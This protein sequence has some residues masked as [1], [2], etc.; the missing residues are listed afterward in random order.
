MNLKENV[1]RYALD[2]VQDDMVL[3]LGSGSTIQ[4]FIRLLGESW[5]REEIRGIQLVPTSTTSAELA[6]SYGLPLCS[7][8]DVDAV[9]LA[10]DGADEVDPHLNLIKGLGLALLREKIIEIHA[11]KFLVIVDESKLVSRLGRGALPVEIVPF[12][13]EAHLRWLNT[14]DCRAELWCDE[15]GKPLV[16]DNGNYVCRCWFDDGIINLARMDW[17]LNMR[18]GIVEH[19]LFINMA[20]EV[21]V[22]GKRNV[23]C[24][25]KDPLHG[26]VKEKVLVEME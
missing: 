1:A 19:G 23:K 3:G 20:D 10:I 9:D 17:L 2:Y 12:E 16:T 11:K 21:L 15:Q 24:L 8:T 22:A 13:A 4:K 25:F 7:L 14:L 6:A 5:Q 26:I 18:P